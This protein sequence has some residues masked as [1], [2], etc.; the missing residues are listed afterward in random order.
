MATY[1]GQDIDLS[2]PQQVKRNAQRGLDLVEEYGRGG[3]DVGRGTARYLVREDDASPEKIR[4]IARYWPRHE[5]D[6]LDENGSDGNAPSNGYIAW[7]LWGGDEGRSWSE[8]KRDQLDRIDEE[9]GKGVKRELEYKAA[10]HGVAVKDISGR[11]VTGIASVF[12]VRD[13]GGDIIWPGAFAKTLMENKR[14]VR[15]MWHHTWSGFGTPDPPT[16]VIDDVYE[17]GRDALPDATLAAAPDALGGLEVRRTYMQTPRGEEMLMCLRAGAIQE[18]SIGYWPEKWDYDNNDDTYTRNLR[19]A[20]LLE[21]SDVYWGMNPYTSASKSADDYLERIAW[22]LNEIKAGR[23]NNADDQRM[24]NDICRLAYEL[25][26]DY[27]PDE[28]RETDGYT[29]D[30]DDQK[31][32]EP[33]PKVATT[34][35]QRRARLLDLQLNIARR[36]Q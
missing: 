26:A 9:Q 31:Q 28:E 32:A 10:P 4:Q 8:R 13:D 16:A 17:V 21:T 6:N 12:G 29:E 18:M 36:M 24:I 27:R 2:I 34:R 33:V 11:T 19:E 15:H 25:G 20:G 30:E 3:T 22:F 14:R 5:G 1:R 23:R 7:M 35:L